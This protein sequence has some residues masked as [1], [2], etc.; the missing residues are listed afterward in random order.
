MRTRQSDGSGL[1]LAISQELALAMGGEVTLESTPG[2]GSIFRFQAP[3]PEAEASA[4]A[5]EA[6]GT[7][8]L[9]EAGRVTHSVLLVEDDPLVAETVGALLR[10]QGHRVWHAP[11]ALAALAELRARRFSLVLMDLDLPGLDGF[12]LAALIRA[13]EDPPPIVALTA[14]ADPEAESRAIQA[15]MQAFLRKPVRSHALEQTL[16]GVA[17]QRGGE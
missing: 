15:G 13:G 17:R 3:L 11:H 7:L 14:S 5:T 1:G 10:G 4:A 6:P 2:Q 9:P 8:P 16:Q 12:E